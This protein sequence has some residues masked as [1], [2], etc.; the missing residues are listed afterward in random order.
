MISDSFLVVVK[1]Q[2]SAVIS[3]FVSVSIDSLEAGLQH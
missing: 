1:D 2:I 3:V